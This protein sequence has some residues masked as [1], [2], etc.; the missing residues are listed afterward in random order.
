NLASVFLPAGGVSSLAFFGQP[1]EKKGVSKSSIRMASALYGFAGI[2]SILLV[3]IPAFISAFFYVSL[4]WTSWLA[5]ALSLLLTLGILLGYRAI[6]QG[7]SL[8]DW[9]E[10]KLP[11]LRTIL[12]DAS[13]S[14]LERRYI[15]LTIFYS[16]LVELCG[17]GHLYI[18]MKALGVAPLFMAAAIGYVVAV[19]F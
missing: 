17:I 12:E 11:V 1:L 18:A 14:L 19:I 10:D 8:K 9:L 2:V 15:F 7:G 6:R 4:G 3:A 13:S 5:L 16:I